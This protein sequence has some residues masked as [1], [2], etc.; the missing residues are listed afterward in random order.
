MPKNKNT[1]KPNN[2][3]V[4]VTEKTLEKKIAQTSGLSIGELRDHVKKITD[5]LTANIFCKK[6][7]YFSN[8]KDIFFK[9]RQGS[10]NMSNINIT[11][12]TLFL[13]KKQKKQLQDTFDMVTIIE[14]G[15]IKNGLTQYQDTSGKPIGENDYLST[16]FKIKHIGGKNKKDQIEKSKK[17]KAE[18][19]VPV[20]TLI[21]ENEQSILEKEVKKNQCIYKKVHKTATDMAIGNGTVIESIVLK[22]EKEYHLCTVTDKKTKRE[23]KKMNL[24]LIEIPD[25]NEKKFVPNHYTTTP[26]SPNWEKGEVDGTTFYAKF[27]TPT[28]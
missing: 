9:I 26:T 10:G 11:S 28:T 19:N 17:K 18:R 25:N 6:T 8:A 3:N 15:K 7:E 16:S 21:S 12:N 23:K 4:N 14:S 24:S 27:I 2:N 5:P 20:S 22:T 1:K 13:T